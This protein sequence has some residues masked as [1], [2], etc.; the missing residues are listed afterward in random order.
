MEKIV[1]CKN[2]PENSSTS[3]VGKHIP[4]RFSMFSIS[5]FKNIENNHDVYRG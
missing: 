5:S 2:N 4:S 3:K 1:G